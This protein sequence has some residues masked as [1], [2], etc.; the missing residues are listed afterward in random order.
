MALDRT[1]HRRG[2]DRE[3]GNREVMLPVLRS[4]PSRLIVALLCAFILS[5][6]PAQA[7]AED[8]VSSMVTIEKEV[9][10]PALA[11][12]VAAISI[13]EIVVIVATPMSERTFAPDKPFIQ[14]SVLRV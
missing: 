9:A 12:D 4:R 2:I 3:V 14:Q 7:C 1:D 11:P 13:S 5:R 8:V 10:M 6:L